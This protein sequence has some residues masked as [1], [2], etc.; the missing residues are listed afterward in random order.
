MAR[1][2]G[3]GQRRADR[4]GRDLCPASLCSEMRRYYQAKWHAA[5]EE[6]EE[7]STVDTN[8]FQLP[9]APD[10]ERERVPART[11]SAG[12]DARPE[13]TSSRAI[14]TT[15]TCDSSDLQFL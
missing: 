6:L 10:R 11:K 5:R 4:G 2:G 8:R 13:D 14:H 9:V 1:L 7:M 3:Q 15:G 12:A